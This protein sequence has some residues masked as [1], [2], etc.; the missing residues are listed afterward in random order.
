MPDLVAG[1]RSSNSRERNQAAEQLLR[2]PAAARI[3][4]LAGVARDKTAPVDARTSAIGM[5][6]RCGSAAAKALAPLVTDTEPTVR[7]AAVSALAD[8]DPRALASKRAALQGDRSPLVRLEVVRSASAFPDREK[9]LE[10]ALADPE[11]SVRREALGKLG[12]IPAKLAAEVVE[13][14]ARVRST[15]AEPL[16]KTLEEEAAL[17]ALLGAQTDPKLPEIVAP[18]APRVIEIAGDPDAYDTDDHVE[19][20]RRAAELL[21]AA[22]VP[23]PLVGALEA[24]L[25]K[26]GLKRYVLEQVVLALVKSAPD[27]AEK[28]FARALAR[29]GSHVPTELLKDGLQRAQRA[30]TGRP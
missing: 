8:V 9:L 12:V 10:A 20:G 29:G 3:D 1:L 7:A 26:P 19:S 30:Q 14:F 24:I 17:S 4:P 28:V 15:R 13:L 27:E 6:G 11:S 22:G 18:I 2:L 25:V 21:A 23:R 16:E 5:L